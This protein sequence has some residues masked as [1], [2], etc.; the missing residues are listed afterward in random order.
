MLHALQ[1]LI[2]LVNV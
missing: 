1:V 2:E